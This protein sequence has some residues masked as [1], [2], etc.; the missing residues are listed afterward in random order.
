MGAIR[1]AWHAAEHGHQ[2]FEIDRAAQDLAR[3]VGILIRLI[4]QGILAYVLKK[5]AVSSSS[6]AVSTSQTIL[7]GGTRVAAD[8]SLAEVSALLKK[9]KLPDG[10]VVW[11]EKNWEDLKRNP[12]LANQKTTESGGTGAVSAA[13]TPSQLKRTAKNSDAP[14]EKESSK[15]P[16][17]PNRVSTQPNTAHFWSGKSINGLGQKVGGA[18]RAAE[19]AKQNGGTTLETLIEERNIKMP[20]WDPNNLNSIKAWEDISSEYANG[21]SGE[22]KAVIGNDLRPGNIW[23]T[24]ELPTLL[25]NP[26]VTKITTVDPVTGLSTVIFP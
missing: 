11:I 18:N 1:R 23:Q 19:I 2:Q 7:K 12:K 5:G 24:K 3:A 13:E 14:P 21:A 22:V 20:D 8:E 9:S 17:S 6:A 4:L 10:F 15:T 25:K 26:N 16:I